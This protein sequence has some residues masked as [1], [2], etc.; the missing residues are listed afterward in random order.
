ML[1]VQHLLQE[2]NR[3]AYLCVLDRCVAGQACALQRLDRREPVFDRFGTSVLQ[4]L[5]LPLSA[6]NHVRG[7]SKV[8]PGDLS[9]K[10]CIAVILLLRE[11][12]RRHEIIV[13]D[14]VSRGSATRIASLLI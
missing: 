7:Q 6:V 2:D 5:A 13:T 11:Q 1:E 4:R 9:G 3:N 12:L 14:T 10:E 8:A